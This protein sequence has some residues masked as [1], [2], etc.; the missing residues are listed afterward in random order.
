MPAICRDC[1]RVFEGARRCPGCN[2]PRVLSHPELLDLTIA[3][4]D[5][6]AFFASIEKR[7]NPALRNRPVIVGGA[8]RGVVATAC[9]I[10]RIRGVHSAMP[11]F[12]ARRLCPDAVVIKPR[13]QAYAA[14]S[15]IIR[16][17]MEELTPSVEPL[18]LDEAFL[19]LAGTQQLHGAPPAV[20]LVRLLRKI[21]EKVGV[22]GSVGLSHNKFLA[23]IAS[24]LDK[25]RG[26]SVI[27]RQETRSFL[28]ERP[29]GL[30]W[31]IG[32]VQQRRL[33]K[34]GIRIF[35]D[36]QN[37]TRPAMEAR[38]GKEGARL[39][40]LAHGEDPR[41]VSIRRPIKSISNETTLAADTAD[42]A[43][44]DG[45]IWRLSEKLADRAKSQGKAGRTIVLKLKRHD[46]RLVTRQATLPSPTQMADQI[47]TEASRLFTQLED[48]GPFRLIGIGL[49]KI[50]PAQP[51]ADQPNLL[52][53]TSQN[54]LRA[55]QATDEIRRKFGNKAI[56]KGRALR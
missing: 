13:M 2:S 1:E 55:E 45:H 11:M 36:V 18:S 12:R 52:D 46:H 15:K 42:P 14:A 20:M 44:I 38:L 25:P 26:F 33:E 39:W 31:G 43:I 16:S 29:I 10:A 9:Y 22:T 37:S 23:K 24:D 28:A 5:C 30:I 56:L 53:A 17:L 49:A 35:G 32:R 21:E 6:D 50:L 19:D 34:L 3:H 54:R 7:D 4:M 8:R 48:T 47:Y 27:G 40:R 51:S 41:P